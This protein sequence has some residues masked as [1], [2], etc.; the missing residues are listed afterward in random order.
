MTSF[1]NY[2]SQYEFMDVSYCPEESEKFQQEQMVQKIV[3]QVE[4]R[5]SVMVGC[6]IPTAGERVMEL[7]RLDRL[8]DQEREKEPGVLAR[9]LKSTR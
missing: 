5:M 2:Y 4:E 1:L 8:I 6:A 7:S 9:I 3:K